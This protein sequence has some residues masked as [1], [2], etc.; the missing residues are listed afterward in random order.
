[1]S[2]AEL[3]ATT[4]LRLATAGVPS[5]EADAQLLV[6]HVLGIGRGELVA[7]VYRGDE[8]AQELTR[9]IEP[10]VVRRVQR[11]PLQ[12]LLGVA[13]FMTFEVFVGPGVFVP[14]PETESLAE[15]AIHVAQTLGV[16]DRE[17]T[18][19]DLCAGSGALAICLAREVPWARVFAVEASDQALPYL[20]KNVSHL[21]PR[22]S[23]CHETVENAKKTFAPGSVDVVVANPPYVP[24]GEKPNELEVSE[25][26]PPEALYGGVDG[27]EV[28][29]QVVAFAQMALRPGGVVMIE[30]ANVQGEKVRGLLE[31]AAFRLV[32][33]EQDLLGRDRFTHG[34]AG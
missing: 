16:G 10:L 34:V 26:D 25:F 18:I 32:A 30:H 23:I 5:P 29:V 19:V 7:R 3:V 6:A 20:E 15:R 28:V 1:M 12:H 31:H 8:A 27:M 24:V 14:R 11:E 17:T 13:P 4:T 2:L 22:V 9:S 21:A 33:T